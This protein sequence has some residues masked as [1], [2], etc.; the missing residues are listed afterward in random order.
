M[1]SFLTAVV[2]PAASG[3]NQRS[4]LRIH[5][6]QGLIVLDLNTKIGALIDPCP[7]HSD[8]LIGQ[9]TGGRH[10]QPTVPVHKPTNEFA[11]GAIAR[12]YHRAVVAA[13]QGVLPLVQPQA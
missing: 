11:G 13:T 4:E 12:V 1:I 3:G 9:R 6:R 10:L 7:Q 2:S 8:L 5:R